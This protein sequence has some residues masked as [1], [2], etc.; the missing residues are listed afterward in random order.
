[1]QAITLYKLSKCS[2]GNTLFSFELIFCLFV[3]LLLTQIFVFDFSA[4]ILLFQSKKKQNFNSKISLPKFFFS[5]FFLPAVALW[6]EYFSQWLKIFYSVS[7]FISKQNKSSGKFLNIFSQHAK[8]KTNRFE[9]WANYFICQFTN[10]FWQYKHKT[11]PIL[12]FAVQF[13]KIYAK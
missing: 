5:T 10:N 3:G 6:I 12:L 7:N 9:N 8:C 1:M 4:L 11:L 2:H 13:S